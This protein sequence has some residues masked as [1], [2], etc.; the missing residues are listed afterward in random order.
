VRNTSAARRADTSALVDIVTVGERRLRVAIQGRGAPLLLIPG[1]GANIEMWA[2]LLAR[3][4]GR[5]VVAFDAPGAGR[6]TSGPPF[7]I[8]GMA[9]IVDALL[10]EL[11]LGRVDVLGYSWGGAVAQ[12]LAHDFPARV[13]RLVLAG[14]AC[15]LGG[16]PPPPLVLAHLLHP[17]RYYSRAYL[18]SIAPLLYAGRYGRDPAALNDHAAQRQ[19]SLPALLGYA[20]Q[21]LAI[22]GWTSFPWLHTIAA[23]TLVL[24]GD[25]DPI[26]P[27]ANAHLLRRRIPDARLHIVRGGGHLFP[28]DQPDVM[29]GALEE[30]LAD[31]ATPRGPIP[32]QSLTE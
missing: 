16:V 7:R 13:R 31:G 8:A 30:F 21:L 3:I 12:Q 10:D 32:A 24:A 23:P 29:I 9:R 14:T 19:A 2:P 1:I 27:V 22:W 18:M 20:L 4:E 15:G 26:V 17:A 11:G 5:Q 6:S 28:F 25:E